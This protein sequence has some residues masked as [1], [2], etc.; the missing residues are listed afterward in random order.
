MCSLEWYFGFLLNVVPLL[1]KLNNFS[2]KTT[3]QI[4]SHTIEYISQLMEIYFSIQNKVLWQH[5]AGDQTFVVYV[6]I[7]TIRLIQIP[8]MSVW[9]CMSCCIESLCLVWEWGCKHVKCHMLYVSFLQHYIL[10]IFNILQSAWHIAN[11]SLPFYQTFV[12]SPTQVFNACEQSN[13]R[14][15]SDLLSTNS[16]MISPNISSIIKQN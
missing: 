9:Y 3:D 8:F 14:P 10:A 12:S 7:F 13:D 15:H 5:H 16:L 11:L 2:R 6:Q 4:G 1:V